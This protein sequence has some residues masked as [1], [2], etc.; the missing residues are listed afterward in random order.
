MN[1]IP[2]THL[3]FILICLKFRNHLK[4]LLFFVLLICHLNSEKYIILK[5]SMIRMKNRFFW[6]CF[7]GIFIIITLI[8]LFKRLYFL[9]SIRTFIRC[10]FK[11]VFVNFFHFIII[12]T[13]NRGCISLF[14]IIMILFGLHAVYKSSSNFT[15]SKQ[16]SYFS[17]TRIW[18]QLL[19]QCTSSEEFILTIMGPFGFLIFYINGLTSRF[20]K[21]HS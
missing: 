8:I 4:F 18:N 3:I 15:R 14:I 13:D 11:S 7:R 9:D 16:S 2:F 10:H 6:N 17:F 12:Q 1:S 19:H 20:K 5:V 21:T